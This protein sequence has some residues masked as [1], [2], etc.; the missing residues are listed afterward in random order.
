MMAIKAFHAVCHAIDAPDIDAYMQQLR[1]QVAAHQH[2]LSPEMAG[3][4]SG[5]RGTWGSCLSSVEY[6][7]NE[8]LS[9]QRLKWRLRR[10]IALIKIGVFG[11][12]SNWRLWLVI[13]CLLTLAWLAIV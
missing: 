5:G 12:W 4:Y 10:D 9:F 8:E 2:N 7:L 3:S 6:L 1:E 13:S 11:I